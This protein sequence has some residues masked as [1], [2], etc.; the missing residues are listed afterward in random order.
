MFREHSESTLS[1][2]ANRL[3]LF[4]YIRRLGGLAD[5]GD[6]FKCAFKYSSMADIERFCDFLDIELIKYTTEP[7]KAEKGRSY[8]SEEHQNFPSIIQGTNWVKQPSHCHI[9]GGRAFIWCSK[10]LITVSSSPYPP[11]HYWSVTEE[12]VVNAEKLELVLKNSP[13]TVV[14][15]P[16]DHE[17]CL[18]PK[19]FP[20]LF[21]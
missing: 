19:Y 8:T 3:V 16:L 12:H 18:C 11:N 17:R 20:T 6:S 7:L 14:D 21:S 4:R 2:W 15:P 10:E 1:E 9:N 13:L 5:D